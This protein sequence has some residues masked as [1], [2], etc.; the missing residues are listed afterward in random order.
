MG[1]IEKLFG[2]QAKEVVDK[3]PSEVLK[4][5]IVSGNYG[6]KTVN[7]S[8]DKPNRLFRYLVCPGNKKNISY[9]YSK[10]IHGD[11]Y[12]EEMCDYFEKVGLLERI[13]GFHPHNYGFKGG[14]CRTGISCDECHE[15]AIKMLYEYYRRKVL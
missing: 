15:A 6:R 9:W 14:R 12:W 3:L 8:F 1:K 13:G 2:V 4:K 11:F 7:N 10:V 5:S